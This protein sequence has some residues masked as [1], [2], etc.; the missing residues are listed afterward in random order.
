MR[1]PQTLW[2]ADETLFAHS[3]LQKGCPS[4][5]LGIRTAELVAGNVLVARK[6]SRLLP[7]RHITR[8]WAVKLV[9]NWDQTFDFPNIHQDFGSI[10]YR[11]PVEPFLKTGPLMVTSEKMPI[12]GLDCSNWRNSLMEVIRRNGPTMPGFNRYKLNN[13]N[14]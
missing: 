5:A 14:N 9:E 3:A 6:D 11:T 10:G 12:Q 13:I 4:P 2:I 1:M 7:N 8:P